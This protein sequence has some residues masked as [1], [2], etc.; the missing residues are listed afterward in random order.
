MG[1]G[2]PPCPREG[3]SGCRLRSLSV[4]KPSGGEGVKHFAVGVIVLDAGSRQDPR[5]FGGERRCRRAPIMVEEVE[6]SGETDVMTHVPIG[7]GA[8]P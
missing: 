4:W 1:V 3:E 8:R 6:E 7:C 5:S 2:H